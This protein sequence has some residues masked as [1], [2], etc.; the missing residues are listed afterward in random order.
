MSARDELLDSIRQLPTVIIAEFMDDEMKKR[1]LEFEMK[2]LDELVP[3]IN[4]GMEEALQLDEAIV[5]VI[6]NSVKSKHIENSYN[7]NDT[8]FTLRT[9]SGKIIGESIYDEEELEDLRDD[10]NVTFLSD[11]F[12][13][14]NDMSCYGER[15]FFVMSSTTS[16][17]FTDADLESIVSKLTVAVPSTETDHYIRNCFNL[18]HDA[19]IGS[20]IIGF[21]E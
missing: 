1:V 21:T 12:V 7:T 16:N 15:Q 8:T 17:F 11:N 4:K 2:R 5:V 10:P 14:Y 6:D 18:E 20:L 9:E 19:E 13:T 3:F